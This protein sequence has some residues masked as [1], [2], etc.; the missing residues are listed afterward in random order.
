VLEEG[1]EDVASG[2]SAFSVRRSGSGLR[3]LCN[4]CRQ[5]NLH[6]EAHAPRTIGMPTVP[7]TVL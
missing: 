5:R 7:P 6:I 2:R 4:F 1:D 3:V